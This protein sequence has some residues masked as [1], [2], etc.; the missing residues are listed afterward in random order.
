MKTLVTGAPGW[1]GT[2][3]VEILREKKRD[4]RCLVL[5]GSDYSLLERLGAEVI[6]GDIADASSVRGA[7]DGIETVF[8]CAGVV[9]PKSVDQFYKVNSL[10]T[11]NILNE[12]A[13]AGVKNFIY[14][15]SNSPAGYNTR[16][17]LLM[18]ETDPPRPYKN[19]GRSKVKAEE[20]LRDLCQQGKPKCTII[21]PCWYYGIRQPERQTSFFRMIKKGNPIIFG[22]GENKRSLSYIDNVIDGLLLAEGSDAAAG[23]TYWIADKRPYK[24]IKIYETIA[25]LLDV[26]NFRPRFVPG[27]VSNMCELADTVLQGMGVYIKEIHVAGEMNKNIACSI[28]KAEKEL[29]YEPKVDLE[30]GMRRSIDWLRQNGIKI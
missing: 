25:R 20:T 28:E 19:Y 16:A 18:K 15:S 29:G 11:E 21:R 3:L 23:Q 10:G 22:N 2:R 7:C 24:T 1:L 13:R 5:A 14:V 30:E 27:A 4:I 17:E 9:H 6:E 12:A 8:H 26:K